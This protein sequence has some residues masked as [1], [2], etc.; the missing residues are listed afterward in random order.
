[1]PKYR[2]VLHLLFTSVITSASASSQEGWKA[3]LGKVNITPKELGW[4]AGYAARKGPAEKVTQELFAKVLIVEDHTGTQQII[5]TWDLIGVPIALRQKLEAIVKTNHDLAP[6]QLLINA[7]HTHSGPV[8]RLYHPNGGKGTPLVGYDKIPTDEQPLRV[9]QVQAYREF[10]VKSVEKCIAQTLD[11]LAPARLSVGRARCAF[12]MNRRTPVQNPDGSTAFR[13]APNPEGPVDH[14]VPVLQVRSA[15][16]DN[17]IKG[18]VFGYA[19]HATTMGN[20]EMHGD[21]PGYAQQYLEEDYPGAI[22]MFINGCSG[23]QNPYPRRLQHFMH[24]HGRS[25]AT[26]VQAAMQTPQTEVSGKLSSALSWPKVAYSKAP[27]RTQLN[28]Q[29][30]TATGYQKLYNEFLLSELDAVGKLPENYPVPVQVIRMGDRF[31]LVGIG[32]ETCVEYSLRLQ[33]ELVQENQ[34]ALIWVAGYSN[35][36]MTYIPS[37]KIRNEGGYEG[38]SSMIYIRSSAHPAPWAP[39]IEDRLVNEVHKLYN[40]LE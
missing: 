18:I 23:D 6:R 30:E 14:Q 40:G 12:A 17:K 33:K 39:G 29:L 16:D 36:V 37:E 22:A 20:L 7:S 27:T 9:A 31:T 21:W 13:N 11:K 32:G 19:C 2:I 1:M 15:N 3:A 25:M 34:H 10:L 5:V 24:R 35:D 8:I 26:A 4:M 38:G 28:Q